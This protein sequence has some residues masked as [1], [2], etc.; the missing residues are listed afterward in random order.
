MRMWVENV[1]PMVEMVED[2]NQIIE[3]N[4]TLSFSRSE[5]IYVDRGY[6]NRI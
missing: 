4:P 2:K 1:T 6:L 3:L 5:Y